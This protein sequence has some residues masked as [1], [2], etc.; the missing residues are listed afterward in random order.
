MSAPFA[1]PTRPHV[2]VAATPET[3]AAAVDAL[4]RTLGES[5][6]LT[7]VGLDDLAATIERA[8]PQDTAMVVLAVDEAD[9]LGEHDPARLA[10]DSPVPVMV[11][12]TA[13][14]EGPAPPQRLV[15]PLDGSARAAQALP[16][17]C[18]IANHTGL[19]VHLVMVIDPSRVIPP[20][21][22][23]DPDSWSVIT[24]LRSTAHWALRQAEEMLRAQGITVESSLLYGPVNACLQGELVPSDVVVM[25][26]HGTGRARSAM[27]SVATRLLK[28]APGPVVVHRGY[29]PGDVVVDGYEACSWVEPLSRQSPAGHRA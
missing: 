28:T 17:A 23:Y 13:N 2:I 20:A 9:R 8:S 5:I 11:L 27:G 21:F 15:V 16:V 22:A 12:R 4:R 6:D 29:D 26:T 25:T 14:G 10:L 3:H 18:R 24:E 19:P 7:S 1:N